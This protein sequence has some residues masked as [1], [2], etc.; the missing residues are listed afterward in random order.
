M[1]TVWTF[2]ACF[3]TKYWSGLQQCTVGDH[4]QGCVKDALDQKPNVQ[5]W[6]LIGWQIFMQ[7]SVWLEKVHRS[8]ESFILVSLSVLCYYVSILNYWYFWNIYNFHKVH[9][10][11]QNM[12]ISESRTT[13]N[14]VQ[15]LSLRSGLI[16]CSLLLCRERLLSSP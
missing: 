7:P 1:K 8:T 13:W 15:H 9:M 3:L 16:F 11:L 5:C 14:K 2:V 12:H 10:I 4:L 6:L